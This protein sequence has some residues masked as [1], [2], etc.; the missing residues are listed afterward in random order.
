MK[1]AKIGAGQLFTIIFLVM[2]NTTGC[3]QEHTET[4]GQRMF[5]GQIAPLL[6]GMGDYHY[7]ISTEDTLAQRFFDQ[8]FTLTY[9]FNHREANRSFR[10]AAIL[11]PGNAMAWWGAAL[12]LG[13]NLNAGMFEDNIPR[14]WNA[15]Q[16][17]MQLKDT[18]TPKEQDYIEALSYRYREHPPEDRTSLDIAYAKAMAKL[19]EKY[20]EDLDAQTLYAEALMDIHPWDYWK[21]NGDPQPWTPKIMTILE[22]VIERDPDHLGANHLYIHAVEAGKP[23]KGLPS[24]NILRRLVPGAGHLVHMPSH[25]YIRTGDYHQGTLANERAA[26]SDNRYVTQC[27]QQGIYPLAYVPHVH[28][29]LWATATMEG[30]S[31]LSLK[32][33]KNTS[34]LVDTEAMRQPGFGTLQHYW[35]I[36]MYDHVRFAR[37][38]KILAYPKPAADLIYPKGVWHYA[39]GMAYIGK[40]DITKASKQLSE[41]QEI[42]SDN[43][44][45]EVTIWNI[46]TTMELMQIAARVLESEIEAQKGNYDP[47]IATLKEAIEIEDQLS[48]NEPPDWFFPARH[49]LGSILLQAG[50]PAEAEQVYRKD[51][52]KFPKNGWSLYGLEQSLKAQ[53]KEEAALQAKREFENSWKYSD[54]VLKASRK[55]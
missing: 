18:A 15:L 55:L 3:A 42:A 41:L 40:G 16:K 43:R 4:K 2:A 10:Q 9:G 48:Y 52:E 17:A 1:A 47:A 49:N 44:L 26:E 5:E 29:F 35:V 6:D 51:L 24:A 12:V 22:S 8:G 31:E 36:P 21:K 25:I 53:G 50:R 23:E 19:A 7:A 33:A 38:D 14:A 28:H 54:I 20:P 46:N 45:K 34:E 30:R 13:P 32:A 39:R 11:D 27:R 37:W